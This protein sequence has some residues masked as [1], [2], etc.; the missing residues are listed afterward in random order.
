MLPAKSGT[1]RKDTAISWNLKA[2]WEREPNSGFAKYLT[3]HRWPCSEHV[4]F[5][6]LAKAFS[7]DDLAGREPC[8]EKNFFLSNSPSFIEHRYTCS[9]CCTLD[10]YCCSMQNASHHENSQSAV[11][12]VYI[13]WLWLSWLHAVMWTKETYT[14]WIDTRHAMA[15][16]LAKNWTKMWFFVHVTVGS[17]CGVC[18]LVPDI[19]LMC[20]CMYVCAKRMP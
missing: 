3:E 19:V 5:V 7:E 20:V 4:I 2:R 15:C 16:W 18:F 17:H 12:F 1:S 13:T 10:T 14:T 8:P 6:Q 11:L 9:S